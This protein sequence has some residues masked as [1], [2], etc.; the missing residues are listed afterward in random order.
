MSW[1][2]ANLAPV[3]FGSLVLFLL[4]G[5]P[6]AFSLAACGMFFGFVGIEM[7]LMPASLL[8][9]LS[10][11]IKRLAFLT[12]H[13]NEPFSVEEGQSDEEKLAAE[14]AAEAEAKLQGAR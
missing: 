7:G 6:V 10:E 9:A 8:Q 4:T 5:F 11:L 14:L 2:A 3:M 1:L 13:R 12:G